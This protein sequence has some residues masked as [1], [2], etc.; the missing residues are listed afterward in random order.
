LLHG[1]RKHYSVL[2][3][4]I[5]MH[6]SSFGSFTI[7]FFHMNGLNFVVC[8]WVEE[9]VVKTFVAFSHFNF[10]GLRASYIFSPYVLYG[11]AFCFVANESAVY[12]GDVFHVIYLISREWLYIH[13]TLEEVDGPACIT[14]NNRR[15]SHAHHGHIYAHRFIAHSHY[16]HLNRHAWGCI[17]GNL[18]LIFNCFDP[19]PIV[20]ANCSK[21]LGYD[22]FSG[23]CLCITGDE[24]EEGCKT[25]RLVHCC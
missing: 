14:I 24:N 15:L 22:F 9:G 3:L 6:S 10:N 1:K 23:L 2:L 21:V 4:E 16:I 18:G 19:S 12:I 7:Y 25:E 11:I 20:A 17:G 5:R 8:S 13:S